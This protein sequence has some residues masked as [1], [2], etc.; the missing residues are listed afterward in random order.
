ME[1]GL[2]KLYFRVKYDETE[3]C[4]ILSPCSYEDIIESVRKLFPSLESKEF[5]LQDEYGANLRGDFLEEYIKISSR[6][7]LL[8]VKEPQ[9]TIL[10][11]NSSSTTT[12]TTTICSI[13]SDDTESVNGSLT[14]TYLN[15]NNE[16]SISPENL[17]NFIIKTPGGQEVFNYYNKNLT[18]NDECRKKLVNI[19]VFYIQSLSPNSCMPSSFLRERCAISIIEIFPNL[20]DKE[21]PKG[22]EAF[23]DPV[24]KK[25][26]LT[27]RLRTILRK[28]K[29][30]KPNKETTDTDTENKYTEVEAE[31]Y[32]NAVE[33]LK[34]SET[35]N[36]ELLKEK[37]KFSFLYRKENN[38]RELPIF[39]RI[40]GLISYEFSLIHPH[41]QE[42]IVLEKLDFF[43][44]EV[45][46]VFE[47]S[48]TSNSKKNEELE[49]DGYHDPTTK[50]IFCL[51]LM[52][53][54]TYNHKSKFKRQNSKSTQDHLIV[55]QKSEVPISKIL[56][57]RISQQ[58][59]IL[60]VGP[61]KDA[62]ENYYI[63]Y[64]NNII[65]VAIVTGKVDI[66]YALD[67]LN[68]SYDISVNVSEK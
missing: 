37:L 62:I 28:R 32:K 64:D 57:T 7:V 11:E 49:A 29:L 14:S 58:P 67:T 20:R 54:S 5:T 39:F 34:S 8:K 9:L 47:L 51:L 33:F 4:S 13:F 12:S 48:I 18:L 25:G 19:S 1:Y 30:S 24:T 61:N 44:K 55:F 59:L 50:A 21:S 22:Y 60:A 56:E 68:G 41:I 2:T 53:P 23:Y 45:S 42:T 46:K 10:D 36:F 31:E 16:N 66:L 17:K 65:S 26:F 15:V 3:W 63:I 35:S 38:I 43:F 52:L 6:G 40:L 27:T